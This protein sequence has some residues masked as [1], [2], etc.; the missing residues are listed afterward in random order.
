MVG[1][2]AGIRNAATD[3][4]HLKYEFC[5]YRRL[6]QGRVNDLRYSKVECM[7]SH[8]LLYSRYSNVEAVHRS[9]GR[10]FG[11]D[12]LAQGAYMK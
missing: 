8:G 10:D 4:H 2:H 6:F 9:H 1:L 12:T 7:R 3:S 11:P 5:H